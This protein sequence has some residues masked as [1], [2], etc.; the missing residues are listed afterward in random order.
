M[1]TSQA[2]PVDQYRK[3]I[4]AIQ[5][6]LAGV[7]SI[8]L[9]GTV[10]TP[11]QIMSDY[12]E[13]IVWADAS[14]AAKAA[15]LEAVQ[16]F[17]SRRAQSKAREIAFKRFVLSMFAGQTATLADFT[18]PDRKTATVTAATKAEAV[19]KRLATRAA[20]HTMGSRQKAKVTGVVPAPVVNGATAL[21]TEAATP[22]R[23]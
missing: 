23:A 14:L 13:L 8:T 15:W 20:R 18:F 7:P 10:T 6:Y 19:A 21:A 17:R 16:T 2:T 9:A 5:K 4:L 12:Q 3:I 1:N 22:A 11:A